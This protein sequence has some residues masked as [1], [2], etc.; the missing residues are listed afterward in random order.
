MR[1]YR[2]WWYYDDD[3]LKR[4]DAW[5]MLYEQIDAIVKN[6][7]RYQVNY[8]T[9]VRVVIEDDKGTVWADIRFKE[10]KE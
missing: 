10:D 8:P 6:Y 3:Q 7:H 9:L 1:M 5:S 4:G 2:T